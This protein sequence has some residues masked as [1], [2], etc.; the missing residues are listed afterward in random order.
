MKLAAAI[1]VLLSHGGYWVGG[2]EQTIEIRWPIEQAMPDSVV[3]WELKTANVTLAADHVALAARDGKATIRIAVPAVREQTE[4]RFVYR[5][6]EANGIRELTSG[7]SAVHAYA[8]QLKDLAT[9][10]AAD[11]L[12]VIDDESK[13]PALLNTAG[14][15]FDRA[16]DAPITATAKTIIVGENKLGEN[17]PAIETLQAF[18]RGGANVLVLKQTR[19]PRLWHYECADRDVTG[20]ALDADHPLLRHLPAEAWSSLLSDSP[21]QVALSLKA[22]EPALAVVHSPFESQG[23]NV[24][25]LDALL[26]T[27]SIGT[28]RLVFC[29]LPL[30][31]AATDARQQQLLVNLIE[32]ARTPPQP[33]PPREEFVVPKK[34]KLQDTVSDIYGR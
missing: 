1:I 28:G 16:D 18:A 17:D 33:T 10:T 31:D 11:R 29:Q 2:R 3:W 14:A 13:L 23:V 27:R 22:D 20:Y 9:L 6:V 19:A 15:A 25:P 34:Q 7:E 26:L 8:D 4:L 5:V 32:Y 12:L 30:S 24:A 21:R